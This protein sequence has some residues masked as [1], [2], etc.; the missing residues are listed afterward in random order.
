MDGGAADRFSLRY[1]HRRRRSG[2]W[3]VEINFATFSGPVSKQISQILRVR[4]AVYYILTGD[5]FNGK[6]AAEIGPT[7]IRPKQNL[8]DE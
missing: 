6:R 5:T 2:I 1:R 3:I 7:P 4:D 8:Q